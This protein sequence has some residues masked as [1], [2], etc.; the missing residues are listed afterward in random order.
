MSAS[1]SRSTS[2]TVAHSTFRL[3]LLR[4]TRSAPARHLSTEGARHTCQPA[5]PSILDLHASMLSA[6]LK[7]Q[8]C[9]RSGLLR[10]RHR[11]CTA[12]TF[13]TNKE[14]LT[15]TSLAEANPTVTTSPACCLRPCSVSSHPFFC[16]ACPRWAEKATQTFFVV[17]RNGENDP[18][19]PIELLTEIY[20]LISG[21][22]AWR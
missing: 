12:H 6:S 11:S 13:N 2:P 19:I 7:V 3:G 16:R 21:P 22:P 15:R 9:Q 18:D 4:A 5:H 10:K 17:F 8:V 14:G 20:G 1:R